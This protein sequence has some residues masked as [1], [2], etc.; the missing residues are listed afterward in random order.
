[1]SLEGTKSCRSFGLKADKLLVDQKKSP[2]TYTNII[3][4]CTF[5]LKSLGVCVY[6][7]IYTRR[8]VGDFSFKLKGNFMTFQIENK[9]NLVICMGCQGLFVSL[10]RKGRLRCETCPDQL[11]GNLFQKINNN[12]KFPFKKVMSNLLFP[13][14]YINLNILSTLKFNVVRIETHYK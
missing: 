10:P 9:G 11:V 14:I 6:I 2:P 8:V 3:F 1:M 4:H 13:Y 5:S 7:Y 12:N